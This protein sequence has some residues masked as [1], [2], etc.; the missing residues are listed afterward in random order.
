M[1]RPDLAT[2]AGVHTACH[3]CRQSGRG[4]RVLRTVSGHDRRRLLRCRTGG[5]EFSARR[6]PA[7][8]KP[9]LGEAK[10]A[11]GRKHLEEGGRVRAPA[12]LVP[13]A[14]ATVARLLRMAGRHAPPCHPPPV[15]GLRPRAW[16]CDGQGRC[17]Q[18]SHNAARLMRVR[19]RAICGTIRRWQ[20]TASSA[21]LSWWA[22]AP[23]RS[24]WPLGETPSAVC[25]GGIDPQWSPRPRPATSR[26][27]G[28]GVAVVIRSRAGP[29]VP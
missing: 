8:V 26:P 22:T 7:L 25:A 12:R 24:P 11:A 2:F 29:L 27:F 6:G 20:P 9:K 5:E 14:Q 3:Q 16:A 23:T 1:A 15:Q 18:K 4:H 19:W 21:C 28:T 13:V 17:V 10:A